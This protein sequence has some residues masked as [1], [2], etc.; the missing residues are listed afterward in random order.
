[1][2]ALIFV[3]LLVALVGIFRIAKVTGERDV[4][5]HS[6]Q[7]LGP[8][9]MGRLVPEHGVSKT[10][11]AVVVPAL[12]A[13][14]LVC[15]GIWLA[16]AYAIAM[17]IVTPAALGCLAALLL[18]F[19]REPTLRQCMSVAALG[20]LAA[21][22]GFL[23]MGIEGLVCLLMAVP[24]A[25]PVAIVGACLGFLLQRARRRSLPTVVGVIVFAAPLLTAVEPALIGPSPAFTV[26]SSIEI[27]APPDVVWA[28]L[29]EFD[30]I[31]TRPEGWFFRAGIAYPISATLQGNG[32]GST[33]VCKFSTG[34]FVETIR[35][36]E[37]GRE[38]SFTVDSQPAPLRE[39]T[40]FVNVHPPHLDG[41]FL[42]RSATFSLVTLPNNRTRLE[43]TSLY[44]NAML[45][46]G[47]WRLWSD[48]IVRAV[49]R[50]VFAHVKRLSE[51]ARS[52]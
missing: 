42:P 31:P 21:G 39:W 27:D 6:L 12:F 33:R 32:I 37:M 40:P 35:T 9:W 45:P 1:M 13:I 44:R 4:N 16:G 43:G 29:V 7:P 52:H 24:L 8:N 17:F 51:E 3:L 28:N 10:A 2:L 36:W 20:V 23:A 41:Y 38:F 48:A 50:R 11:V 46:A 49:H 34:Q 30:E 25:I 14:G 26:Q 19:H 15:L 5:P 18:A 47:Y 22:L